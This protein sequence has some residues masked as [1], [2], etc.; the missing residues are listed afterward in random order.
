MTT[1]LSLQ[2]VQTKTETLSLRKKN[3]QPRMLHSEKIPLKNENE[4]K[5]FSD[6]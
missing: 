4:I 2:T 1:E 3:Y 6:M 5:T